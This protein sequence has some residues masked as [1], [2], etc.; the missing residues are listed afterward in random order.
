[1]TSNCG[2]FVLSIQVRVK[3]ATVLKDVAAVLGAEKAKEVLVP[4][5]VTLLKDE[6]P[7][8]RLCVVEGERGCE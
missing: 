8:T 6:F 7:E 2:I 1:M 3:L 5:F 4:I